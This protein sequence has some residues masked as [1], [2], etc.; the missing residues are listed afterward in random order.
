MFVYRLYIFSPF[1][2]TRINANVQ[3][4]HPICMRHIVRC[5]RVISER[6]FLEMSDTVRDHW[7]EK[8]S[9]YAILQNRRQTQKWLNLDRIFFFSTNGKNAYARLT[10]RRHTYPHARI[11]APHK[12]MFIYGIQNERTSTY[13]RWRSNETRDWR[14]WLTV[15][16]RLLCLSIK[17]NA[18]G[19]NWHLKN[20]LW[21]NWL[22][23]GKSLIENKKWRN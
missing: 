16:N 7:A 11:H 15:K 10:R 19:I 8:I 12:Y 6:C 17:K 23:T 22:F 18:P 20:K 9:R 14:F 1:L 13:F 5:N 2:D 4:I 21:S 3:V